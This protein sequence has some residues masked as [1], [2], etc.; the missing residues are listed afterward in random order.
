[1]SDEDRAGL[2]EIGTPGTGEQPAGTYAKRILN[3][4][5][6]D[7]SWNSSRVEGNTY[8]LLDTSRLIEI[9][10][11]AQGRDPREAQMILNH[12]VAIEILVENAEHIGFN[13]HTILNLHPALADNLLP[14]PDAPG[15]LRHIAVAI[16]GSVFCPLEVPHLIEECFDEILA[17]ASLIRDP[18]E[19]ALFALVQLPNLPSTMRTSGCPDLRRTFRLSGQTWRHYSSRRCRGRCTPRPFSV[20]TSSGEPNCSATSSSGPIG[21]RRRATPRCASLSGS[22]TR[23]GALPCGD[24]RSR[25][26]SHP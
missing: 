1:M 23:S 24:T 5:L 4:L 12:K 26:G 11:E 6:I 8:S 17:M 15:R 22:P 13:R 21:A 7:L 16:E 14:D 10:E 9:G 2:V 20:C 25:R 18:F 3:R 19:Q